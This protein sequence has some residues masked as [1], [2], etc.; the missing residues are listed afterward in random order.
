[1]AGFPPPPLAAAFRFRFPKTAEAAMLRAKFMPTQ[2][3]PGSATPAQLGFSFPAEWEKHEATW[4]GWPHN[5]GDWPGKFETIPW[6]YGEMVRKISAGENIRLIVRH[7]A[8]EKFAGASSSTSAWI[9]GKIQ[10]VVH[11]T[12][13]GWTRDTGPVFVKRK[14][15]TAIVHFHFNGWAKYDNWHKDTKV[16]ETAAKLLGKKLFHARMFRSGSSTPQSAIRKREKLCDRRRRHRVEWQRHA[17]FHRG[18]LSGSE[19]PGA[20]SRSRQKGN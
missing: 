16:P 18:M 19:N 5:A 7:K 11:P 6:V 13:R 9:C 12:N 8:D 3:N 4:L 14:N 1:M 10:F 2:K 17:D 20:Q 15:E